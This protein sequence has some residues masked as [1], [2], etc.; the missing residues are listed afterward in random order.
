MAGL[1][2]WCQRAA[3][4]SWGFEE[5]TLGPARPRFSFEDLRLLM[6]CIWAGPLLSVPQCLHLLNGI[7]EVV[8][9]Q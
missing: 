7:V 5:V 4:Y 8:Q 3:E 2:W 6:A 9:V 1:G